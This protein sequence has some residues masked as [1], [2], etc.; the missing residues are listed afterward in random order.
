VRQVTVLVVE[1]HTIVREGIIKLI[2]SENDIKVIG[3]ADNQKH[4]IKLCIGKKPDIMVIDLAILYLIGMEAIQIIKRE[5]PET[6]IIILSLYSE[7]EYIF[8]AL[9]AGAAGYLLKKNAAGNLI[10]AIRAV[11]DG[12]EFFSPGISKAVMNS[13]YFM[14]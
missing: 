14:R 9:D 10:N 2:N 8:K 12:E 6:R 5:C 13:Y 3:E 1:D 7:E 11:Y 4:A